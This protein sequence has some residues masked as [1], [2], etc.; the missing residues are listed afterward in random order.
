MIITE[1]ATRSNRQH[2]RTLIS[3]K[4]I[5]IKF[6]T[7]HECEIHHDGYRFYLNKSGG[8]LNRK[9][10]ANLV[11]QMDSLIKERLGV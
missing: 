9:S 10:G 11:A 3:G 4:T 7:G 8:A 5:S 2:P 1:I 6:N